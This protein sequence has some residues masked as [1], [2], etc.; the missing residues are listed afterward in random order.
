VRKSLLAAVVLVGAVAG[1]VVASPDDESLR[2]PE[3]AAALATVPAH[4]LTTSYTLWADVRSALDAEG[5]SSRASTSEQLALFE[6][7]RAD[8]LTA[9]SVLVGSAEQLA[10]PYGLNVLDL[11]WETLA[12]SRQGAAIVVRLDDDVNIEALTGRLDELGYVLPAAD[13]LDG[14]VWVGGADLVAGIEVSLTPVLAHLA[15]IADRRLLVMSDAEDYGAAGQHGRHV[16]RGVAA[17]HRGVARAGP[18][19]SVSTSPRV[20]C[21]TGSRPLR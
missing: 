8:D 18:V 15:V 10:A 4:T 16:R 21:Q 17:E 6:G 9:V 11:Q 14:A 7:A 13:P 1:G 19:R 2:R 20:P 5:T 3:L 12:Q